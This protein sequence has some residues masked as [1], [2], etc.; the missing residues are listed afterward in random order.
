MGILGLHKFLDKNTKAGITDL[1]CYK[2]KD[3]VIAVDASIFIYQFAS[4]IKSSVDDLKTSDGRITTHIYGIL[5]KTLGMIKKKLKPIFI[6][7]GKASYLKQNVL[8]NRKSVKTTAN[9]EIKQV[10]EKLKKVQ[11]MLEPIPDTEEAIKEQLENIKDAKVLEETLIKLKKRT[12]S[13]TFKQM[14]ECKEIL[15]LLGIQ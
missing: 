7:D 2:L 12:V 14:E 10:L 15:Q 11:D 1:P 4:A 6:F 13:V 8:D 3:K 5:T 9:K